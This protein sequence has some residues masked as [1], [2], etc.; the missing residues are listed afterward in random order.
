MRI[1][2][3]SDTLTFAKYVIIIT[4]AIVLLSMA[5]SAIVLSVVSLFI[6][7]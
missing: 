4:A 6:K 3:L 7:R 2:K 5:Y 1:K